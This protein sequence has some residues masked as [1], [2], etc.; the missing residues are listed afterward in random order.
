[1]GFDLTGLDPKMNAEYPQ[2]YNDIMNKYGKDGWL[3]WSMKIPEATK[4]R[5]F[6]LQDQFREDNPCFFLHSLVIL[7][8]RLLK[9]VKKNMVMI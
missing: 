8:I 5:Y 9:N 3:N 6:Q 4:D 2:E 1:M 7:F